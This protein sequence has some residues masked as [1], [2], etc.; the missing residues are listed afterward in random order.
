MK[1][2]CLL[3]THTLESGLKTVVLEN[4]SIIVTVLPEKGADLYS[5]QYKPKM[6][7][8]LLWKSPWG[9]NKLG[10]KAHQGGDSSQQWLDYYPGGWQIMFPNAGNECVYKGAFHTFHGE[11]NAIPWSV[12]VSIDD[13]EQLSVLFTAN[14]TRSPF[15]MERRITIF[16]N[17]SIIRLNEKVT[18][19]GEE[20]MDY[21]WGQHIAFGAPFLSEDC[22]IR[23]PAEYITSEYHDD[24]PHYRLSSEQTNKWPMVQTAAGEMID[25]SKIPPSSQRATDL[26]YLSGLKDGWYAIHN[27]RMD[28]TVGV[29]W[30]VRVLPYIWLW[31]ELR[32]LFGHPFFGRSYVM[33]MEPCST[34]TSAGLVE[35]LNRGFTRSLSPGQSEELELSMVLF[36]GDR[37]IQKITEKGEVIA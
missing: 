36:E 5:I 30:D 14:L 26:A 27:S 13:G 35:S 7:V 32:G 15:R 1:K 22:A 37:E 2:T 19:L 8:D 31:Q 23:V 34:P 4:E 9:A 12:Q 29:G 33:G 3:S 18:N 17:Q 25:F 21:V 28:L 6:N 24:L 10:S 16:A 20:E 11:S